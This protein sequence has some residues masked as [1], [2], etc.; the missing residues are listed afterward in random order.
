M[1][2]STMKGKT[3]LITG[4]NAGIGLETAK[5]L[6]KQGG[7]VVI[8]SRDPQKGNAA[9]AEIN[10]VATGP[11]AEMLVADL[12]SQK[13]VRQLAAEFLEKYDRLDVLVNNAG[14]FFSE[15]GETEDGIERQFAINHLA[16]FLLTNLLLDRLK[17]NAPARVVVVASRAHYRGKM[18][19]DDPGFKKNYD[20][21]RRAYGQ[22]KLANVLFTKEL[23]RKL[24]GTGVTA[25]CLHPG[26]V[27]TPIAQKE[28]SG[29]YRLGWTLW[30]PFMIT[31]EQGAETSIYLA[32]SPEVEGVTGQYFDKCK[33]KKP[34]P[35]ADDREIAVKLWSLSE[36][37][38]QL[39]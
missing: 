11:Q 32:S 25:N 12:S 3:I 27:S 6:A 29:I 30:R 18:N 38:T 35:V 22:S 34:N 15:Y 9:L 13:Q 19:F 7:H 36:K 14:A 26:V 28:S 5:G 21:F 1:S 31:P 39:D 2:T 16:S 4:G 10:A 20:G 24:E 23:A 33:A 17:A 8:V 37:L